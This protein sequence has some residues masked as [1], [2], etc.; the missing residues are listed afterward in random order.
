MANCHRANPSFSVNFSNAPT[1]T[2]HNTATPTW[3]P[4][5]AAVARSPAPTP[6]AA[7]SRPGPTAPRTSRSRTR[8]LTARPPLT[9]SPER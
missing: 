3:L 4:V 8:T 2:A 6:V 7:T 1:G 5:N 9:A